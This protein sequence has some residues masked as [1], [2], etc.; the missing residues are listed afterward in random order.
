MT[1]HLFNILPLFS[2]SWPSNVI[3]LRSY[4]GKNSSLLILHLN[5]INFTSYKVSNSELFYKYIN[6]IIFLQIQPD[7]CYSQ[8][9]Y[10]IFYL[11]EIRLGFCVLNSD[12][13]EPGQGGGPADWRG[14]RMRG[15]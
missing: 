10:L 14:G 13:V 5:E 1:L 12:C 7:K 3:F 15:N 6:I 8:L 4:L 11:L 2:S 9:E